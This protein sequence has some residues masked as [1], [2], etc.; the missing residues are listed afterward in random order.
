MKNLI[1]RKCSFVVQLFIFELV[2]LNLLNYFQGP[3][4]MELFDGFRRYED[5]SD[6]AAVLTKDLD[7]F[8]MILQAR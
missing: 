3:L 5:Q 6:P 2:L 7:K 8:D 1:K 4:A